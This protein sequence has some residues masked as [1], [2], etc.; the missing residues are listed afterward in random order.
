[1][2]D[3]KTCGP[4]VDAPG[5]FVGYPISDTV[6]G[7]RFTKPIRDAYDYGLLHKKQREQIY[8]LS[9][10]WTTYGPIWSDV[11]GHLT[12]GTDYSLAVYLS[13]SHN[14]S[15]KSAMEKAVKATLPT[16]KAK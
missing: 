5:A 7:V 14:S 8:K 15:V 9:P 11:I 13:C 1:M 10:Y 4:T 12:P 2:T 16:R 3:N 6:L